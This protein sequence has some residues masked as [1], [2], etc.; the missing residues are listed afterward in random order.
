ILQPDPGHGMPREDIIDNELEGPWLE[1]LQSPHQ[2]YLSNSKR[3][4]PTIGPEP[5]VELARQEQQRCL[6]HRPP[7]RQSI[8]YT[9]W[10]SGCRPDAPRSQ[11]PIGCCGAGTPVP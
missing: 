10:P 3:K 4:D 6:A 1:Q 7:A 2:H 9:A 11:V 5:V 8:S